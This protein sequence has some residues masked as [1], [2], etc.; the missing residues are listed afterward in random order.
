MALSNLELTLQTIN[1][2]LQLREISIEQAI[3]KA[4]PILRGNT[5][6]GTLM[7]L[8]N[9]LQGYAN[10]LDFY[11]NE[12][13]KL[14]DY[15]V[16]SGELKLMAADGKIS[17]LNHPLANRGRYFLSAPVSW[18]EEFLSLPGQTSVVELPDLTTYMGTGLG[19]IICQCPK[20]ELTRMLVIIRQKVMSVL[21]EAEI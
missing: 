11:Q 16:V 1:S 15:R 7:W 6:D 8:V 10:S 4:L 12:K 2:K 5:E 9:E 21:K 13:H 18:L 14:P 20:S 3:V 19:N 17:P